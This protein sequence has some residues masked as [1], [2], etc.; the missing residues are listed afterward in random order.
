MHPLLGN[1]AWKQHGESVAQQVE[2]IPFKDGVLGSSPSWFTRE[3][4]ECSSLFFVNRA[5]KPYV[6]DNFFEQRCD[7]TVT[8]KNALRCVERFLW[9]CVYQVI[10]PGFEPGTHSL[11]GCCSIQLSYQTSFENLCNYIRC[12]VIF[13]SGC[14]GSIFFYFSQIKHLFCIY[15]IL[16]YLCCVNLKINLIKTLLL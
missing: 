5:Y 15:D 3:K 8:Q 14:K 10:R 13:A 11:E 1:N 2:H 16:L 12:I 7:Y 9:A 6:P 4:D